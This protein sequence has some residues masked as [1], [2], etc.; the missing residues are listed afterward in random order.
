MPNLIRNDGAVIDVP[1]NKVSAALD[2]G[3]YKL[4]ESAPQQNDL[5]GPSDIPEAAPADTALSDVPIAPEEQANNSVSIPKK[6]EAAPV[7]MHAKNLQT[8]QSEQIP[9][10]E[11]TQAVLSG[12]HSIANVPLIRDDGAMIDVPADKIKAALSTGKYRIS[13]EDERE[14]VQTQNVLDAQSEKVGLTGI[15]NIIGGPADTALGFAAKHAPGFEIANEFNA[16]EQKQQIQ[17]NFNRAEEENPIS[18]DVGA[19]G[20]EV[21]TAAAGGEAASA[22]SKALEL[23]GLAKVGV[24]GA[25]YSTVPVVK[26]LI[27]KDPAASAEA[28][29]TGIVVNYGLHGLFSGIN[30]APEA[31]EKG[32]R[33]IKEAAGGIGQGATQEEAENLIGNKLFGL[34]PA[35]IAKNRDIIGPAMKAAKIVPEDTPE[36]ALDKLQNLQDNG[37]AIG[38]TIKQLDSFDGKRSIIEDSLNKAKQDIE[39]LN[40]E[41]KLRTDAQAAI[42]A[43]ENEIAELSK[44]SEIPEV[45]TKVPEQTKA[46]TSKWEPEPEPVEPDRKDFASE[47][48]YDKE[49]KVYWDK[50]HEWQAGGNEPLIDLDEEYAEESGE[51][52]VPE[53]EKQEVPTETTETSV[54]ENNAE[55]IKAAQSE[56][57]SLKSNFAQRFGGKPSPSEMQMNRAI[58]PIMAE[59]DNTIKKGTFEDTQKLKQ[60]IGQQTNFSKDNGFI[61]TAR[62][63]V[64][65][66]VNENLQQAEDAAAKEIGSPEVMKGLQE[67]RAGYTFFKA[68]GDDIDRQVAKKMPDSTIGDLLGAHISHRALPVA[69]LSHFLHIPAA[70]GVVLSIGA[71]LGK[72]Y[73]EKQQLAGA[74]KKLLGESEQPATDVILHSMKRQDDLISERTRNLLSSFVSSNAPKAVSSLVGSDNAVKDLLPN[75][76]VGLSQDQQLKQLRTMVNESTNNPEVFSNRIS[77]V[78]EPLIKEGLPDV[79]EAYTQHQLRLMKVIQTVIPA[80]TSMAK[81]HPFSNNVDEPDISAATKLKYQRALTIA[82]DPLKLLDMVKNNTITA[83]DV[84][85]AAATNPSTLQKMRNALINEAMKSKPDLA[86]QHQ[87]SLEIMMGEKIDEST[88]QVPVLQSAYGPVAPL[89]GSPAGGKGKGHMSSKSQDNIVDSFK[90]V[91]QSSSGH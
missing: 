11:A 55:K 7:M 31:I 1:D 16:P 10:S 90:T 43:K 34:S 25:I 78:T 65:G 75:N 46:T 62:K 49:M 19:I 91:S 70:A 4:A 77:K 29:A 74:F 83:G 39:G 17:K 63:R 42:T 5:T 73:I 14:K 44:T 13:T 26:G 37:P 35:K 80:D 8:G 61:N 89:G 60:W 72:Q 76:G 68:F 27:N 12:T 69:M 51:K 38:K 84:A 30:A 57:D 71:K 86:Y 81:A 64:Y 6:G 82:A 56:L 41:L 67:A 24:E 79:A 22:A 28:L 2:T 15:K 45:K 85:I 47:K 52:S 36:I 58:K 32:T 66:I 9:E 23:S 54:P 59:I 53:A 18:A 50:V 3:N 87:L 48:L 40:S 88:D 33:A 21:A 20:G